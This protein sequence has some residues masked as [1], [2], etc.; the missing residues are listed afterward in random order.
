MLAI[1]VKKVDFLPVLCLGL[2]LNQDPDRLN[3]GWIELWMEL[4]K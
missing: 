4:D 2:F 1:D 3:Y